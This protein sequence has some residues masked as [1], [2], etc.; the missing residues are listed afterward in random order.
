[1]KRLQLKRQ[2][3][4]T[5]V[6][7]ALALPLFLA[8]ALIVVDGSRGYVKKRE[9][10]N[11]ADAA[12]LA[13]ARDLKDALGTCD[14]ACMS[15]VDGLVATTASTYSGD[16]GGP[17]AL[18]KCDAAHLTNCYTWPYNGSNAKVEV[19]LRSDVETSFTKV[20][21]YAPGF[22]KAGA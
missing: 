20:F 5:L 15:A 3:G 9:M 8:I 12:A 13:A 19:R 6:L 7:V 17:D 21:G 1:M 14:A 11:A 2:S 10:Q 4:Q 16:N 18:V 22:L